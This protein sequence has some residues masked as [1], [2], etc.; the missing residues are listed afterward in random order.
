M[1]QRGRTLVAVGAVAILQTGLTLAAIAMAFGLTM[2]RFD[3]GGEPSAA[4]Q[5]LSVAVAV[6]MFPLGQL[7]MAEPRWFPGLSGY[8]PLL[9]NGVLWAIPLVAGW[10]ALRRGA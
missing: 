1:T 6:L 10:R 8:L 7:A 5:G 4:E 9:A 2:A 3:E